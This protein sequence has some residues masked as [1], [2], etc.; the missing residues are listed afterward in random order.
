MENRDIFRIISDYNYNQEKYNQNMSSLIDLMSPP[1]YS[2]E[3]VRFTPSDI[4]SLMNLFDLS[5][6]G[7]TETEIANRTTIY[8]HQHLTES[9]LTCPITLDI[10]NNGESVM[11]INHCS[12]IFKEAALRQWFQ[13]HKRCPVCRGEV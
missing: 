2:F 7:L 6:V 13:G 5:H 11:K 1:N 4:S 9:P 8:T 10:I 12:H 3:V